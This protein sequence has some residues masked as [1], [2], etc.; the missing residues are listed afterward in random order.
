MRKVSYAWALAV[1][2]CLTAVAEWRTPVTP[3]L[4]LAALLTVLIAQLPLPRRR[5]PD[6]PRSRRPARS[7]LERHLDRRVRGGEAD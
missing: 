5:R 1:A 3:E 6:P 7:E 4:P 2:T